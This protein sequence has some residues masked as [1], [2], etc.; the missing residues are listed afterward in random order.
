[1]PVTSPPPPSALRLVN[2]KALLAPE[3]PVT[4]MRKGVAAGGSTGQ[5]LQ[6]LSAT[7]YDTGWLTLGT[8]AA[9]TASDYSTTAVANGLYYPLSGTP[10]DS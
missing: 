6:K 5:V 8:M 10:A 9:Q 1:M 2:E 7:S 4:M 3:A